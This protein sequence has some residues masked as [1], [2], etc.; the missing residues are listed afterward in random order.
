MEGPFINNI[1]I[2]DHI[3]K[4]YIL[5]QRRVNLHVPPE[6]LHTALASFSFLLAIV[7]ERLVVVHP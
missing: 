1:D 6:T 7:N 5:P 2:C 4:N 3:I